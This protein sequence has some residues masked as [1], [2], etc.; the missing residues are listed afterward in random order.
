[1]PA[2]GTGFFCE[3][4]HKYAKYCK[5]NVAILALIFSLTKYIISIIII[6][7]IIIRRLIMESLHYLLMKTQSM[8]SHKI[9]TQ[10]SK[11]GLTSGQPKVLEFLLTNHEA[12]Q[13]TIAAYCEIEQATV[14]SILLRMEKS[15]LIIRRNK[16][17]NRRSNFVS[18]TESGK[19]AAEKVQ[20]IFHETESQALAQLSD[21]EV[22]TVMQALSKMCDA[23]QSQSERSKIKND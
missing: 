16:D 5:H 23:M 2:L 22:K 11:I 19:Q 12:D 8:F 9:L 1:M 15:G 6:S 18:L 3:N 21:D 20:E 14:G 13:K 17:G 10:A 7:I 4:T